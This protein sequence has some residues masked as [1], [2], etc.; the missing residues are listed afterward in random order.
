MTQTR[1]SRSVQATSDGKQKLEQ[2]KAAKCDD[3]GKH[4]SYRRIAEQAGLDEKT[5]K[6]FFYPKR[7]DRDSAL[8]ITQVLGLQLTDIVAPDQ[9]NRL[10]AEPKPFQAS[11]QAPEQKLL[12]HRQVCSEMLVTKRQLTTNPLTTGGGTTFNRE[13]IYVPLGLVERWRQPL[14]SGNVSPE[15][16][17]QL[18]EPT[19][20][21]VTR[22]FEH[23]E[24]FCEV[25]RQR[26][27]PKSQGKRLAI[28]GEPGVGKTTLL[29][30]IANWVF[31][32]T[33]QDVAIWVSL[34]DLQGRTLEEY[35]L[36]VW[37]KDAL[38][39]ARVTPE[40]EDALVELFN[41]E[42][43]WLLLDGVDEMAVDNPKQAL[44]SQLI[45]WI[46]SA[47]VVLTC[48]LNVWDAGKNALF[49]FDV[50][51]HLDFSPAQVGQ[52]IN[53]WFQNDRELARRLQTELGKPRKERIQDLVK[54]PLRLALLCYS[55]ARRQGELPPTK[56]A[57]YQRFV[58][59]FYEWKQEHFPTTSAQR[60]DLNQ[61]LG[62]LAQVAIAKSSSRFRLTRRFVSSV[63]GSLDTPLFQLA[64]QLGWLNQ[65]G[66]AAEDPEEPVYAFFHP[67]FEEYFAARAIDDWHFFLNH[68]PSN[69]LQGTYR[70]F[71]PQWKEVFL[72]WLGR[73]NVADE[74][75]DELL[76]AL[77][78]FEDG[79]GNFYRIKA[80]FLAKAAICELGKC[81]PADPIVI[82]CC[83]WHRF[84][85]DW[86]V[87]SPW[88]RLPFQSSQEVGTR[89]E[90]ADLIKQLRTTAD[91][92]E[93]R[94]IIQEIG[95]VGAGSSEA[96]A[97]L[98][99]L[100]Q[101]THNQSIGW[102]IAQILGRIGKENSEVIDTLVELLENSTEHNT[103]VYAIEGLQACAFGNP[104]AIA[105]LTKLL[106]T[107][108]S[109]DFIH[110]QAAYSL[111][112]IDPGNQ[113]AIATLSKLVQTSQDEFTRLQAAWVLGEIDNGNNKAIATL[114]DFLRPGMGTTNPSQA[115]C[116]L[117]HVTPGDKPALMNLLSPYQ[118]GILEVD[119]SN[120]EGLVIAKTTTEN[121][122]EYS[123]IHI[124]PIGSEPILTLSGEYAKS[125]AAIFQGHFLAAVNALQRY[126]QE[127]LE[128]EQ[129]YWRMYEEIYADL[130][131]GIPNFV[132]ICEW[133]FQNYNPFFRSRTAGSVVYQLAENFL[134]NQAQK[135]SY[136]DFHQFFHG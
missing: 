85:S 24:F 35:L 70:I 71:E 34:A 20:Y 14:R 116:A 43:V 92:K 82:Q 86:Q 50:Y 9:E 81:H 36:G 136:P 112:Q 45:G 96:V 64:V 19:D 7:V 129:S 93:L 120:Q 66:V 99:E 111:W 29:Q 16:G 5:V 51:R 44:A 56:A 113:K 52:F 124:E 57:L 134:W 12:I 46:A 72:L 33:E 58:E 18:Y 23:D 39:R 89:E 47:R 74:Q 110:C 67:T 119:G 6:N 78:L 130:P 101:E 38:K 107:E 109:D 108:Q 2:A 90:V 63:L 37:L 122:D 84:E 60:Q 106:Q 98:I 40:M 118:V 100:M 26:R 62:R 31:A 123:L 8:A 125:I 88:P 17:S 61:A 133:D 55:W 54:H 41:R 97:A 91:E 114:V 30:Q 27:S 13:N 102:Q 53:Q 25:L 69:P 32:E 95:K 83:K 75:K 1:K 104:T 15:K 22:K 4:W 115:L 127:H 80:Y 135:M 42:R 117:M 3:N 11:N 73:E 21:E 131:G 103:L 59:A 94:A 105:A 65:V 76:K 28:I 49:N 121:L 126:L 87:T 132:Y 77:T 128:W 68:I 79:C 48:R 10:P